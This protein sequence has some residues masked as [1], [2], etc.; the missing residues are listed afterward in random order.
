MLNGVAL[1]LALI[2]TLFPVYW[3]LNSSL[4]HWYDLYTMRDS[5]E[6]VPTPSAVEG[7]RS[8][9][10]KQPSSLWFPTNLTLENYH[11]VFV[12]HED[13]MGKNESASWHSIVTSVGVATVSTFFSII[14]GLMAAFA[15]ARYRTGGYIL[16]FHVLSFRMIP[17]MV[18]AIP[19]AYFAA[20][21]GPN[22]TPF[23]LALIYI[24]YTAPLSA[25]L[26]KGFIEQ[27]PTQIED[28]A[29]MD[30]LSRWQAHLQ[31]TMPLIKGGLAATT[32]FIFIL[33]WTEGPLAVALA[34]GKWTTL[35][36]QVIDKTASPNLQAAL[37]VLAAIPPLVVGIFIRR[38]LGRAFTLGAIK[39]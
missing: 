11:H 15:F 23:M 8:V 31:I 28:A 12:D 4:K 37:A 24:A 9:A 21:L 33:N 1:A 39:N 29:M 13:P 5:K 27:V 38:H 19:F 22:S 14:F 16:P 2:W 20:T 35:P 10:E 36:V 17:A 3:T 34:Y 6:R 26:L 30:G 25:W 32:L 18:I 7:P